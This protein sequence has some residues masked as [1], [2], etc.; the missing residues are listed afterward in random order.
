MGR[1]RVCVGGLVLP[2]ILDGRYPLALVC[3]IKFETYKVDMVN[4]WF[5]YR[6]VDMMNYINSI[7]NCSALIFSILLFPYRV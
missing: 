1:G 2:F 6:Y 3:Y 4:T 7:F 5:C